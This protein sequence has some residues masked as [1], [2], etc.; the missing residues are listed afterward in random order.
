MTRPEKVRLGEI[1][2]QQGLLTDDQLRTSLEDRKRT[3]RR[4]GRVLV[5]SGFVTEEQ[6]C[7]ALARQL[8]IP[9][10]NLKQ[11]NVQPE[12]LAKLPESRARRFRALLL[13]DT[14]N[15]WTVGMA[16]PTDLNAYDELTRFLKRDLQLAVVAESQ[17]LATIDRIYR[18]TE[19]IS[20][21]VQELVAISGL[22]PEATQRN[23]S[24]VP[25]LSNLRGIG[26]LF[27]SSANSA[28]KNELV[29]LIKPTIIH[30]DAAFQKD[31]EDVC[32]RI[33]FFVR[34]DRPGSESM[35]GDGPRSD[36]ARPPHLTPART[37]ETRRHV[38]SPFRPARTA[39]RH[40]LAA[41]R[42]STNG[43]RVVLDQSRSNVRAMTQPRTEAAP[44]AFK[45]FAASSIVAP[46]VITSSR[47][48]MFR[49]ATVPEQ[50][51][52]P[53]TLP[54]RSSSGRPA[55]GAVSRW[56]TSTAETMRC[57]KREGMVLA[58]SRA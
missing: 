43:S 46:V 48:T 37:R 13:E 10:V 8:K 26:N 56:R 16:D 23:R 22:M 24:G 20:G 40:Q 58:I 6:I 1:L 2:L 52:A 42:S 7:E 55:C 31:L 27:R 41:L 21:L 54:R 34:A 53:R 36:P 39:L 17:L 51:N 57:A 50:R 47:I 18:R 45:T 32:S 25:G 15:A 19:Q 30:G 35:W 49:F 12:V 28:R 4:L 33:R 14:G 9:F 5:E 38:P 3:G 29:I 44:A 11:F